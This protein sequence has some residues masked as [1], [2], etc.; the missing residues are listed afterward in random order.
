[1]QTNKILIL[2]LVLLFSLLGCN[3]RKVTPNES[4]MPIEDI[5]KLRG[6]K[7]SSLDSII[8][9]R[10]RNYNV[11]FL[12]NYYDCSS[13]IDLGFILTKKIDSLY[14]VKKVT[15]VSIMGNPSPYQRRNAYYEYIYSDSKD[16][17]RKELKYA[18]TPVILLLDSSNYIK[19]Y[20]LPGLSTEKEINTFFHKIRDC[21][22]DDMSTPK[23]DDGI[24]RK[25][26]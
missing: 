18:Q 23:N 3:H 14:N 26:R 12:F 22:N 25:T 24:R 8:T 2:L 19:E 20:I 15:V 21:F 4:D 6:K 9:D 5:F 16:L 17:I 1:M 7:I 13:C 10:I 11:V